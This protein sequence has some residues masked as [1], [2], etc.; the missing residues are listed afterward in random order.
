MAFHSFPIWVGKSSGCDVAIERSMNIGARWDSW[1][2]WMG[3][4]LVQSGLIWP[5]H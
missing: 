1:Q 4:D 2:G 5:G 3:S